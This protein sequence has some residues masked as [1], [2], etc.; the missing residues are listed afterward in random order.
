MFDTFL[1]PLCVLIE[2]YYYAVMQFFTTN[3]CN[4]LYRP[5][6]L[7]E[8]EKFAPFTLLVDLFILKTSQE[9]GALFRTRMCLQLL[10]KIQCL[11]INL[12]PN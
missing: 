9:L 1:H 7:K 2:N 11:H 6:F 3:F 8:K 5:S 10:F 4:D 12:P